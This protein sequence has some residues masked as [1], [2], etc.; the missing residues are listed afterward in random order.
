MRPMRNLL[1]MSALG[2]ALAACGG[3]GA[4]G[5]S[6][7]GPNDV[8]MGKADAPVTMIEYASPSCSHCARFNNEVF[9]EFKA[10]YID[11]GQVRYALREI[12]TPPESFASAS[13][14][15]AKCAGPE[16]YYAVM[17]AVFRNQEAIFTSGDVANGLK[18]IAMSSGLSEAEFATCVTDEKAIKDLNDRVMKNTKDG[19]DSTPTFFLNGEKLTGELNM[20]QLD[21]AVA[22]AKTA[23]K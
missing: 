16:K 21:A 15:M 14:L 13:F 3:G 22:K 6:T 4:T 2:L 1:L 11:S 7:I 8:P 17:E 10:K 18:Q 5:V 12:I 23:K 20:T 19:I 9:P